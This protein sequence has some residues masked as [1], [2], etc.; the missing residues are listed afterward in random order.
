M[1][2]LYNQ[3][4]CFTKSDGLGGRM[5]QNIDWP[6]LW[7]HFEASTL[8]RTD[9]LTS[10]QVIWLAMWFVFDNLVN[11][12]CV[13]KYLLLTGTEWASSDKPRCGGGKFLIAGKRCS[14][15]AVSEL[16]QKMLKQ[17]ETLKL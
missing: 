17:G 1:D 5:N 14:I 15:L 2:L 11:G 6:S 7:S 9:F 12:S 4:V 13:L 8:T 3:N 16:L 10:Q